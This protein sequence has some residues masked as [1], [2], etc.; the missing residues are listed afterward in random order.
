MRSHYCGQVTAECIG[1]SV[2]ICAWVNRRRDHGGVIFLDM[3][4]RSGILQVV[5]NPDDKDMFARADR[6]RSE[7][8]LR[9]S[10]SVRERPEGM[11]NESIETGR[12]ELVAETMEVLNEAENLPFQLDDEDVGE[13]HRLAHRY[14]DLRRPV[15]QS[16][17]RQ[18][19]RVTRAIRAFF[20]DRD[21]IE[22]ETP[23]L[24]RTT[25]EGARD[26]LV[27]SRVHPGEFYA[28]PQSPQLFKQLLMM[29]GF[30]R[31]YQI[32]RCF[33][34]EDLRA[35]RQPEF[36]QLDMEMSFVDEE[37][38]MQTAEA[39]FRA[40]FADAISV[41]LPDPFPRMTYAEAVS[42][43]GSDRPNLG[44]PLELVDRT[45]VMKAVEFKVF[46]EPAQSASGRVVSLRVPGGGRLTRKE[47]DDYTEYVGRFGA[48][49]LAYIKCNEVAQGRDGL[50]SPILKFLPDEAL[51]AV[52][53]TSGAQDGD[54][55]FFGAGDAKVVNESMSALLTRLGEDL[56]LTD[57]SGWHPLWVVEFPMFEHDARAG[58]W[59][60]L[61]HPFTAPQGSAD[62]LAAEPGSQLSRAYDIVLNGVEVGGGSI[63]ISNTETQKAVF[64]VLGM[65]AAEADEQFGFLLRALRY[66]CPPH[67]G[68]AIGLDRLVMLMVGERSIR[69]VIVFPKTQTANCLL[70]ESPAPAGAA[71]LDELKLSVREDATGDGG[72]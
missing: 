58:R 20:D 32:A 12:V 37:Q 68:I 29:S 72:E 55:L 69:D 11:I 18:R 59:R 47:I 70:S 21:F 40:V 13:Q 64:E 22:I 39:M 26:Y 61:H 6:V 71:Q 57:K 43:Y 53:E 2:T 8:V 51:A 10:G 60:A 52:L 38:V 16:N 63:R 35:D 17:I 45:D 44:N 19:A 50:Q 4:D 15:M 62:D 28:L 54:L 3:R 31:Y 67:G 23:M 9:I 27:P 14:I 30:D 66:G 5:F 24:T 36:T 49:G 42:R 41:D 48:R 65:S 7:Y 33:R 56:E 1:R 25:P 34:D 46:A